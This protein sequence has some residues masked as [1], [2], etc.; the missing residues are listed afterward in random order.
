[1]LTHLD[2]DGQP[3]MVDISGKTASARTATAQALVEFPT[4]TLPADAQTE[5]QT[6][7]GPVFQTAIIAGTQAVKRT[8]DLVPFCHP[9]PLNG[10]D[11]S[12]QLHDPATVHIQCTVK[13]HHKT[14]VEMEALTGV[15]VA[16]LTI[17]DMCKSL[18]HDIVI[19]DT[20]LLE[21]TGGK[22]NYRDTDNG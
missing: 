16:A 5:I 20:R 21:K 1:M 4:G 22:S 12:I 6:K 2:K 10:I 18:S 8:A 17:Y 9:L 19:R 11:F 15:T 14:G 13:T 3:H 7:K